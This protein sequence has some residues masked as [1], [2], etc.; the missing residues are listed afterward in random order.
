MEGVIARRY[1]KALLGLIANK[2]AIEETA[3]QLQDLA[4]NYLASSDF[5]QVV[6]NPKLT[7]DQKSATVGAIAKG[8]GMSEPVQKFSRYLVSKQRFELIGLVASRFDEMALEKL[9]RARAK[10]TSAFE[11]KDAQTKALTKLLSDYTQ[12]EVALEVEVDPSILGGA[13]TQIGSLVLDGSVK[14]RLNQI[15]ETISRG[16]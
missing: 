4:G 8:L 6:S 10:V 16:N 14:N 11:M 13:V 9:G 2:E 1:A 15:R 3:S 5:R 7:R 12:K